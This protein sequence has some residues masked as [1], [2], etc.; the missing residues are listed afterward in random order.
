MWIKIK[1]VI[2]NFWFVGIVTGLG[3]NLLSD[4]IKHYG[5][6][7]MNF[8][9]IHF[10]EK[11]WPIWVG[12]SIALIYKFV[13]FL[14]NLYRT[15]KQFKT[16]Q[17]QART[18]LITNAQYGA[19]GHMKDKTEILRNHIISNRIERF[20]V[21]NET[22]DALGSKDPIKGTPKI[23]SIKYS[24]CGENLTKDVPE[25]GILSLPE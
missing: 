9:Y 25:G 18:L 20:Q 8:L 16:F 5:G 3:A 15:Y 24:Y 1:K 2:T 22:L 23:L 6:I 4:L 7:S 14:W 17:K 21:T 12:L 10:W 11:V 13:I 19:K